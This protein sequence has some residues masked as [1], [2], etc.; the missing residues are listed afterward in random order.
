[1][2]AEFETEFEGWSTDKLLHAAAFEQ[3]EYTDEALVE[4]LAL[5]KQREVD[6]GDIAAYRAENFRRR[7]L[8]AVCENCQESLI[9]DRED[10]VAGEFS[11]P[12]CSAR[13]YVT[14]PAI[15]FDPEPEEDLEAGS[16]DEEGGIEEEEE[17]ATSDVEAQPQP[18]AVEVSCALCHRAVA[19]ADVFS[20][21]GELYCESCYQVA[22][23]R[24]L[25][26]PET[27]AD[28]DS[29]FRQFG[30]AETSREIDSIPD[31]AVNSGVARGGGEIEVNDDGE[32]PE[33]S[34]KFEAE[35]RGVEESA[36]TARTG[37]R[38]GLLFLMLNLILL[39]AMQAVD[40]VVR[41]IYD[42]TTL[43]WFGISHI[44]VLGY[45]IILL[46]Y[47][48]SS[49]K[50]NFFLYLYSLGALY[51]LLTILNPSLDGGGRIGDYPLYAFVRQAVVIAI[52]T[53]YFLKSERPGQTLVN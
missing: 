21:R 12:L 20:H 45:L 49:F 47:R 39:F 26:Q 53:F 10:I 51:L 3:S 29:D 46:A 36:D 38:G 28:E 1:M 48:K 31:E 9:L 32:K 19:V 43:K 4:I 8:E 15:S 40:L 25:E 42:D 2:A 23:S 52:W 16:Q 18:A 6:S 27:I 11:C 41:P 34:M 17:A 5:L 30:G 14:F 13:Q 44:A 50:L 37:I 33:E 24:K 22:V 35:R 7:S